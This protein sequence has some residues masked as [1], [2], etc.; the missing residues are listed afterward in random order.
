M[1]LNSRMML[2]L[3]LAVLLFAVQST[4]A[5]VKNLPGY[6]DLSWIE[7]PDD[8]EE[9]QDIDL[10]AVLLGIA[11]DAEEAGDSEL[12]QA[13]TMVKSIRVKAFSTEYVDPDKIERMVKRVQAQLKKDDWDRLV[14]VKDNDET[15]T[16]S[17][18]Y[19]DGDM[20]GLMVVA[21]EEGD[22]VAFVNV[23]GDLDLAT[24]IKLGIQMDDLD[25]DELIEQIDD[26]HDRG[27]Y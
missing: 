5:N 13:L 21:A 3:A 22:E 9:I 19:E 26:R 14:Y 15:L 25:L 18:K 10:S 12:A 7:I 27:D 8:A 16:I 2:L 4:A 24:L 17:T 23:V 11:A 1:K 20:V 6:I